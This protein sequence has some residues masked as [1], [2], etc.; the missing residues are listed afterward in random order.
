MVHKKTHIA[1]CIV[2]L[3][4]FGLMIPS[5]A[6]GGDAQTLPRELP[7]G[8]H[9]PRGPERVQQ[10]SSSPKLF[11]RCF[12]INWFRPSYPG[13]QTPAYLQ[14]PLES[15][16]SVLSAGFGLLLFLSFILKFFNI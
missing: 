8:Q 14:H 16:E 1:L 3:I 6:N 13:R 15:G 12:C 10:L 7:K 2:I 4:S 9:I 11:R 5:M